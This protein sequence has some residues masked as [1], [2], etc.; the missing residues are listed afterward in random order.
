MRG[1]PECHNGVGQP[2]GPLLEHHQELLKP[3]GHL[4]AVHPAGLVPPQLHRARLEPFEA[5][6]EEEDAGDLAQEFGA[7]DRRAD[8]EDGAR[9]AVED[10]Q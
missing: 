6:V 4:E 8:Q 7:V 1:S 2:H 3:A 5:A 9:R 10:H